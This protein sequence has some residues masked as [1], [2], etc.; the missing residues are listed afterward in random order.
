S[1]LSFEKCIQFYRVATG[2]CAFGVK[3]FIEN[4]NIEPKAYTV[5]EII[6][7]TKGQYGADK[8][9]AFFS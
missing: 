4:H 8:L 5:A 1:I 7:R 3:Q 2:A 6:E 9:I